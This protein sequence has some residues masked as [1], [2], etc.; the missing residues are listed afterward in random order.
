MVMA[1][2]NPRDL[3]KSGGL[4]AAPPELPAEPRPAW[5]GW[6]EGIC[7]A[8]DFIGHFFFAFHI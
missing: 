7:H 3:Y 8:I 5:E 2:V 1:M 4:Y 6:F